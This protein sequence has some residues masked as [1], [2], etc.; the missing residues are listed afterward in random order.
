MAAPVASLAWQ[1]VFIDPK[2]QQVIALA[3]N[4]NRD[5]RVA[6]LNIEKARAGYRIRRADLFPSVSADAS[7]TKQRNSAAT[8]TNGISQV[9]RNVSFDVGLT[10][11]ELDL[12]GRVRSL[13]DQALETWMATAET[14]RSTRMS[15]VSEVAG[16][17]LTVA[18]YRPQMEQI[19][20]A[21]CR[22]R[23]CQYV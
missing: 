12:F 10:S 9:S 23:V 5:L 7:Q 13:K 2:L 22:E 3:L 1:Q 15:L 14:Q 17:W 11:W 19:G 8:S 21:S 6:V 18:A 16:S 4:N 20:R